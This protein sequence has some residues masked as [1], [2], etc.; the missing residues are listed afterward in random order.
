MGIIREFLRKETT[1]RGF[2]KGMASAG[3]AASLYGCSKNDDGEILQIT[4]GGNNGYTE[5]PDPLEGCQVFYGSG[6]HNCG[7][8]GMKCVSKAYVKNGRILRVISDDSTETIDGTPI[9]SGSM[10][11]TNSKICSR[12]RSYPHRLYHAG[13]LKYP[14]KQTLERGSLNG[15]KRISWEQAIDEITRKHKAIYEAYGPVAIHTLEGN[16]NV[17]PIQGGLYGPFGKSGYL[18]KLLGGHSHGWDTYS[19]HQLSYFKNHYTGYA[20]Q[21]Y[22]TAI[23]TNELVKYTK[24]VMMWG[25]NTLTTTNHQSNA[26]IKSIEAMRARDG[27]AEVIFIGP[28]CNDSVVTLADEW[29]QLKP[30]TDSALI[31]AMIYVM[32]V[33]TFNEDGSLKAEGERWLDPDYIDTMIYGFFDS[34]GYWLNETSGEMNL[35][36]PAPLTGEPRIRTINGYEHKWINEVPDGKSFS[37]WIMGDD[38]RLTKAPYSA[39]GTYTARKYAAKPTQSGVSRTRNMSLCSYKSVSDNPKYE[40]KKQFSVKKDP[41]WAEKITGVSRENIERLAKIYALSDRENN[42][43]HTTISGA[44]QKKYNGVYEV[45]MIENLLSITKCW[46][47]PGYSFGQCFIHKVVKA[48]DNSLKIPAKSAPISSVLPDGVKEYNEGADTTI[49]MI[50]VTQ[51]YNAVAYAMGDALNGKYTARYIPDWTPE[52]G[53]TGKSGQVYQDNSGVKALVKRNGQSVDPSTGRLKTYKVTINGIEHEYYEWDGHNTSDLSVPNSGS[54]VYSGFRFIMNGGGN[55]LMNQS[56]NNN[57][58]REIYEALP[59]SG[60]PDSAEGI[61]I[62]TIDNFFSPSARWSDYVLPNT[63]T[64]EQQD[65]LQTD[66]FVGATVYMPVISKPQGEAMAARDIANMY[67]KRYASIKPEFSDAPKNFMGGAADQSLEAMVKKEFYEKQQAADSPYKGM[68]WEDFLK[69]PFTIPKPDDLTI[70]EPKYASLW[71]NLNEYLASPDRADR[72]F[73]KKENGYYASELKEVT[74]SAAGYG[75]DFA[76]T[77]TAPNP[78]WRMHVYSDILV[79]QY[80]NRFS[81]WHGHLSKEEQ[82]QHIKD[83]DGDSEAYPIPMYYPAEDFFKDAYGVFAGVNDMPEKPLFLTTAH[84]RYRSHST[85]AENPM[86]RELTHRILGGGFASGNDWKEYMTPAGSSGDGGYTFQRLSAAIASGNIKTA[87]WSELWMNNEDAAERGIADGDIVQLENPIGKVR[88]AARVTERCV[89]GH[90]GL[91]EGCLYDPNP[92]DGMDD[93]G[94]ANTLMAQKPSRIDQGNPQHQA[95]V[96]VRKV[97]DEELKNLGFKID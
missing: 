46:G 80:E 20:I 15:F 28:E 23:N 72:A 37:A 45:F 92:K 91:H 73:I 30:G 94:C 84:D 26:I 85:H 25:T 64:W 22:I 16:G 53:F 4:G 75:N 71:K 66:P 65:V 76:E 7:G 31:A 82:G 69:R 68:T 60:D 6:S 27:G 42:P 61:C 95:Y 93:G 34:P 1:R 87:S 43:I 39:G 13:R 12:C 74:N 5:T 44:F 70:T 56:M 83:F 48:I 78:S 2:L 14:M 50:S 63:T 17:S 90:V 36:E 8:G 86:T 89:K 96:S 55:I 49:P 52:R 40:L 32:I 47:K 11:A 33:N 59:L 97:T 57:D 38:K 54:P 88:C 29:I 3:T 24:T 41:E 58:H 21:P 67:A 51:W 10:N 9:Y 62:T 18:Y 35:D 79:W 81:K 77:V 19:Y